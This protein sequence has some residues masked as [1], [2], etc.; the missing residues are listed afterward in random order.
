MSDEAD[1]EAAA[2]ELI[3]A[4]ARNDLPRYFG[5]FLPEASF[6]FPIVD[7]VMQSPAEYAAE[8]Q[9]WVAEDDFRVTECL[10]L[11]RQIQVYGDVAVFVHRTVTRSTGHRGERVLHE[12]ETII[13][14]KVEGV[15]MAAHEHVS[16]L[17]E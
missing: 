12:R 1:V 3:E 4:F 9:K 6:V 10:S 16:P 14:N 2:V 5:A 13:F 15:W 17:V 7:H 8:W 11:D